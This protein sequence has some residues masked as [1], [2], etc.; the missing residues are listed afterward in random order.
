[1][2]HDEN[3][4]TWRTSALTEMLPA[5]PPRHAPVAV[6]NQVVVTDDIMKQQMVE[7]VVTQSGM[8]MQWAKKCLIEC[9]S[10]I[11][12]AMFV[13]NELNKTDKIPGEAFIK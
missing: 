5:L 11:E 8:N 10:D 4:V 12:Q 6:L 2:K 3:K 9:N 1:M 7:G 13:F